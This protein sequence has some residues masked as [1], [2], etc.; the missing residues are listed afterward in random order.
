MKKVLYITTVSRTINSFLVPHIEMLLENG[1]KVDCATCIDKNVNQVLINKGVKIF[2]IPFSRSP[3]SFGNIKAFK[4][5]IKLQKENQYDIIHVHTP[6]ASIYGRLLKL[7]F[8]N[9]KTIYTAHGYHFFKGGAKI[10]WIIYYPIEKI[11]AKLTD[12]T[13]NINKE[14]YEITKKR[15]K[16][17]KC[18]LVNGVGL[19]LNHYKPLSKEKQESKRKE[20]G[21]EKD[22]FVVIMIAELN[23]NKN[24]IQFIKA[25]ELLKNRY[26][27]IRAISVGEGHKF[28]ELQKE[29]NNRV[30]KNNFKLLGF[31]TDINELI[32]I[33]DIGILLSHREGLPR[34][35]MEL[36]ANGKKVI[37]TNVR[38][39]RDLVC[40]ENIGS[41]VEVG[42]FEETAR[43]IEKFYLTSFNNKNNILKEVKRYSISSI[44]T[45]LIFVYDN[46]QGGENK[47]GKM[48][49]YITNE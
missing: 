5:L 29:I 23:E 38:G 12:V 20:L 49:S 28:E 16:P 14:D 21:L 4:E 19:D 13:I 17:K 1:Y 41:L 24:Q 44:L 10:G 32:N 2:N 30:L 3:L 45:E 9:L 15:L 26:P 31:R 25:M 40:N 11:M 37:A 43:L 47:N 48:S 22:D 36:M 27:N 8:K 33:S 18:Y 35:I 39:C 7:K 46:L 34:N 42:D 6:I